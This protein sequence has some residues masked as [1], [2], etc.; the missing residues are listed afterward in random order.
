MNSVSSKKGT[1]KKKDTRSNWL[2]FIFVSKCRY[3]VFRKQSSINACK[4][5]FLELEKHG[6]EFSAF[7]FAG[8]HVH[9]AVNVPEKYSVRTA[10]GMLKSWSAK[11]VFKEKPNFR[12]L[13]PRGC[14]WSGYEHHQGF[15]A[16]EAKALAYIENQ[17]Q[18]HNIQTVP[19]ET[20][21]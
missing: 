9:F 4:K 13:Y 1:E 6:F 21:I 3:K 11:N 18:Y 12:K 8:T 15:G 16:D 7:G 19:D 2:A 14:F 20:A 5:G 17:A 10:K